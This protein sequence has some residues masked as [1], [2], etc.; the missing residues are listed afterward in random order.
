MF[1]AAHGAHTAT[2]TEDWKR[3]VSGRSWVPF[4]IRKTHTVTIREELLCPDRESVRTSVYLE[5]AQCLAALRAVALFLS[6]VSSLVRTDGMALMTDFT[7]M[8]G[9][10]TYACQGV[11]YSQHEWSLKREERHSNI[12][13][14]F[15]RTT[16]RPLR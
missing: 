6:E 12:Y 8:E 9:R 2:E 4:P 10:R 15:Y 3:A 14:P 16:D 1:R 7:C 11:F 13:L 5:N